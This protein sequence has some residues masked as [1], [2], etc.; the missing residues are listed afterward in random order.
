MVNFFYIIIVWSLFMNVSLAKEYIY[1]DNKQI[2]PEKIDIND[3][4]IQNV[5]LNYFSNENILKKYQRRIVY[6][7]L[8]DAKIFVRQINPFKLKINVIL[9][10]E[11]RDWYIPRFELKSIYSEKKIYI[12][13]PENNST[14]NLYPRWW[15]TTS[16]GGNSPSVY[17]PR[18]EHIGMFAKFNV[19]DKYEIEYIVG[20]PNLDKDYFSFTIF[21]QDYSMPNEIYTRFMELN[22]MNAPRIL[23]KSNV[24]KVKCKKVSKDKSDGYV[25]EFD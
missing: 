2:L 15:D 1:S 22:D 19:H 23:T 10:N 4:K 7:P 24:I 17:T 20:I 6:K 18:E 5:F 3:K 9:K 25:C 21:F 11:I 12:S 8:I 16:K 14:D 13:D